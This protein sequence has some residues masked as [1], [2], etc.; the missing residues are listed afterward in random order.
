MCSDLIARRLGST[1][2]SH[3]YLRDG[4]HVTYHNALPI[5][6]LRIAA[7]QN[8]ARGNLQPARAGG[9]H[10]FS[11]ALTTIGMASTHIGAPCSRALW[12]SS[13]QSLLGFRHV[14]ATLLS[15][16]GNHSKLPRRFSVTRICRRRC[17]CTRTPFQNPSYGPRNAWRRQ[18]WTQSD[19]N[20]GKL[21]PGKRSKAFGL[22]SKWRARGDS[23][24]RP[25]VPKT[26]SNEK[27]NLLNENQKVLQPSQVQ[28]VQ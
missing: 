21:F 20:P 1:S 28:P 4:L 5:S 25:L 6:T 8:R 24:S 15:E 17:R 10:G 16:L 2:C 27:A 11:P 14:H 7:K 26:T 23:N 18:F 13:N 19:P 12:S 3:V 22:R 9:K